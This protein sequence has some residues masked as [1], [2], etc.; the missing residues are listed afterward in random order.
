M[1]LHC[2]SADYVAILY[3]PGFQYYYD[4][5]MIVGSGGTR[6]F[7]HMNMGGDLVYG[8]IDSH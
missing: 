6:D 5:I 8:L 2:L 1:L 3:K 7:I 4:G